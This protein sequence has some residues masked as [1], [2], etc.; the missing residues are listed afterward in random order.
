MTTSKTTVPGKDYKVWFFA[1]AETRDNRF[2]TFTSSFITF[3]KQ[4]LEDDFDFIKGVYYDSNII[5][6]VWALNNAQRPLADPGRNRITAAAFRQI[7][8]GE[9]NRDIQLIITSSSSGSIVAAQTA[10]LLAM[11]NTSTTGTS[12]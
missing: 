12:C 6:V 9:N 10:C 7:V 11:E 8:S 1:G 4:I 3:M 2:N 5:N